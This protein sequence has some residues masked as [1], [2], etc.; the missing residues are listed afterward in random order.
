MNQ[1]FVCNSIIL[2][3]IM[4]L[5][6]TLENYQNADASKNSHSKANHIDSKISL[7]FNSH[8][9][10]QSSIHEKKDSGGGDGGIPFP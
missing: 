3:T 8:I 10:D 4:V 7:P 6:F 2:I 5:I 1:S 9:A